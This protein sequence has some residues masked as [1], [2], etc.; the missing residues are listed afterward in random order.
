M[1]GPAFS[2]C[3][4]PALPLAAT[5][6]HRRLPMIQGRLH[7]PDTHA[8]SPDRIGDASITLAAGAGRSLRYSVANAI[9]GSARPAAI[10]MATQR[11]HAPR[12]TA[13]SV[14][15]QHRCGPVM[16]GAIGESMAEGSDVASRGWRRSPTGRLVKLSRDTE[17]LAVDGLPVRVTPSQRSKCSAQNCGRCG[18]RHPRRGSRVPPEW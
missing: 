10:G 16:A 9:A 1:R 3:A 14:S 12:S 8:I 11:S 17:S 4:A 13:Q 7:L 15:H 5:P 18:D 6:R 2:A